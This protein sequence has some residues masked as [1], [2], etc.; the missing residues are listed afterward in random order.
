MTGTAERLSPRGNLN[1][2]STPLPTLAVLAQRSA[3]VGRERSALKDGCRPEGD[4]QGLFLEGPVQT[5]GSHTK[6]LNINLASFR[7]LLASGD[8]LRW[9]RA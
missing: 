8:G 5:E 9:P 1:G 2:R 4:D 3:G 6:V 7:L